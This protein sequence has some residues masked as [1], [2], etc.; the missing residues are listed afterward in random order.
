MA[1]LDLR[2]VTP[3]R[4]WRVPLPRIQESSRRLLRSETARPSCSNSVR[5]IRSTLCPDP[6]CGA[7]TQ[8]D[9]SA[10]PYTGASAARRKSV[11]CKSRRKAIESL[12]A[13]LFRAVQRSAPRPE[14][15]AFDIAIRNLSRAK[16]VSKIR[17]RADRRAMPVDGFQPSFR[18]RQ[19]RQRRHHS[20]R[21]ARST[22]AQTMRR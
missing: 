2:S 16:L 13:N 22:A 19:K 8:S 3:C 4:G 20:E 9:A 12:G 5:A 6:T 21:E 1:P 7:D 11:W 15:E 18:P 10:R 17:S 14:I